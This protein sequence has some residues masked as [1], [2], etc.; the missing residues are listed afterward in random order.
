M[1]DVTSSVRSLAIVIS[2]DLKALELF[3]SVFFFFFIPCFLTL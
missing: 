2:L 3:F 1:G